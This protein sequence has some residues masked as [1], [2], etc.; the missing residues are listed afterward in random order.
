MK[1][2]SIP[3]LKALTSLESS[4]EWEVFLGWL[5]V[6]RTEITHT[7]LQTADAKLCGAAFELQQIIETL[8][9]ARQKLERL[10]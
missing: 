5:K 2:A 3:V 10:S 1:Q 4:P 6:S 9:T 8:E 7:A